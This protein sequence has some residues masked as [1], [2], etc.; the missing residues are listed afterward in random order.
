[1]AATSRASGAAARRAID[2]RARSARL[3]GKTSPKSTSAKSAERPGGELD[4]GV[5]GDHARREGEEQQVDDQVR[6]QE[7]HQQAARV[8]E[9]ARD[10]AAGA[11]AL[12]RREAEERRLAGAEEGRGQ[13][14]AAEQE[15]QRR[16]GHQRGLPPS[17][18]S[19]GAPGA[20][21]GAGRARLAPAVP[22]VGPG[23]RQHQRGAEAAPRVG[24]SSSRRPPWA[25]A[26]LCTIGSPRPV[27]WPTS[28]V[29]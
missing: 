21:A 17:R 13:H 4:A 8:L 5:A 24:S 18:E 23:G 1:M 7:R 29:V 11:A 28:L 19:P 27:P 20:G 22:A 14:Q 25:A 16:G 3:F 6:E 12:E 2:V 10:A 9:Q 15:P 26:T